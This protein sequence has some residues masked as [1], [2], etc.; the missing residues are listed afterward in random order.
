MTKKQI[1]ALNNQ[2]LLEHIKRIK[3]YINDQYPNLFESCVTLD[4]MR[5]LERSVS[6]VVNL[7]DEKF[8]R[9]IL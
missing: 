5:D 2:E 3:E 9:G 1:K 7:V 4:N 6:D 8:K